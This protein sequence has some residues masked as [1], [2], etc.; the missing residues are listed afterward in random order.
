MTSTQAQ[1]LFAILGKL[2]PVTIGPVWH[3]LLL[4]AGLALGFALEV[5]GLPGFPGLFHLSA[6][7]LAEVVMGIT[8]AINVVHWAQQVEPGGHPAIIPAPPGAPKP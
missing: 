1:A 4:G 8:F 2:L 6:A 5:T 7:H 3:R